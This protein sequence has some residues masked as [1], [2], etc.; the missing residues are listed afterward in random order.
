MSENEHELLVYAEDMDAEGE[1]PGNISGAPN[2][3]MDMS[4][5]MEAI[6]HKYSYLDNKMAKVI[7]KLDGIPSSKKKRTNTSTKN[8][9][10]PRRIKKGQRRV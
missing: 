5:F 1:K 6:N 9:L 2:S 10:L 8:H 4:G 7:N 3:T